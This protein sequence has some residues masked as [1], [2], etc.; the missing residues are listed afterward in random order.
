MRRRSLPE[1]LS[2]AAAQR[3][4]QSKKTCSTTRELCAVLLLGAGFP[5]LWTSLQPVAVP[6]QSSTHVDL[7]APRARS[8]LVPPTAVARPTVATMSAHTTYP[9][10]DFT[11]TAARKAA[12]TIVF[13][14]YA[15]VDMGGI[16]LGVLCTPA[17][18][19][20]GF[21]ACSDAC[22]QFRECNQFV[23]S[24]AG[25]GCWLKRG[26]GGGEGPKDP[27][28]VSAGQRKRFATFVAGMQVPGGR[29]VQDLDPRKVAW[30]ESAQFRPRADEMAKDGLPALKSRDEFGALLAREGKHTGVE[31]GVQ[32]GVFA[33]I[34]LRGWGSA[35]TSYSLVDV[36]RHLGSTY[37][38]FANVAQRTQ[39][40]Y[41]QKALAATAPFASVRHIVR[42]LTVEAATTFA[43]D[44]LDFV[45]IDARHDYTSVLEDMRLYWPKLRSGGIF[46]GHDYLDVAEVG[47]QDWAVQ[48]DGS[49]EE[50]RAVKSAVNEFAASQGIGLVRQVECDDWPSWYFRKT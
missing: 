29:G 33:S 36:W 15:G 39:E 35:C 48:P 50:V 40:E 2:P 19:G 7:K 46:A 38:D 26:A 24:R 16:D 9:W 28:T 13:K 8:V 32:A 23:Y 44:S 18:N 1:A 37:D 6:S 34:T 17:P 5:L 12:A 31:L 25:N 4:S 45:Y 10:T 49:R 22:A 47:D 27:S 11:H 21:V 3:T 41:L 43:D 42:N 30:L 14:L 20:R